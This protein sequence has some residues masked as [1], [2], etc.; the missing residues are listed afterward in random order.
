MVEEEEEEQQTDSIDV[1]SITPSSRAIFQ[2]TIYTSSNICR[3]LKFV[4]CVQRI[5]TESSMYTAYWNR[6][7][8]VWSNLVQSPQVSRDT[9]V[10]DY[11]PPLSCIQ[12]FLTVLSSFEHRLG[13]S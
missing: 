8:L 5:H 3:L 10:M 12:A 1:A 13:V 4:R 7:S 2:Q 9:Y 6:S 11:K